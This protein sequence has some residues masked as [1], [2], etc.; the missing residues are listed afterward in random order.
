[1]YRFQP[2]YLPIYARLGI[3]I[4]GTFVGLAFMVWAKGWQISEGRFHC[5]E[6]RDGGFEESI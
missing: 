6:K 5:V 4:G 1:M 2:F 3:A